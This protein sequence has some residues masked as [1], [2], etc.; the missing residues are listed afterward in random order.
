VSEK[1]K[2]PEHECDS[3]RVAA[4]MQKILA[5]QILRYPL[6]QIQDIY[7]LIYQ[8][9][10]G[11]EHAV[12]D[13]ETARLRLEREVTNL[14]EG[15]RESI[16]DSI[17][18]TG[19]I[20]RVNLRPY[21]SSR[22]NIDSLLVGFL[23][24]ASEFQGSE[25]NIVSYWSCIENLAQSGYLDMDLPEMKNFMEGMKAK[26]LPAVH[27]SDLYQRSYQPAYRVVAKE[28]L[29]EVLFDQIDAV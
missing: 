28:F 9:A 17:S 1:M 18:P 22:Y 21:S 4:Q 24:T 26:G 25:D 27:H 20:V 14:S 19:E 23:N 15:L 3:V 12:Q 13:P 2:L 7:K 29:P 5:Q 11:C 8:A 10:M 6:L 16:V